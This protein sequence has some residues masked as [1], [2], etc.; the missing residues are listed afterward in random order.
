M[1]PRDMSEAEI[2]DAVVSKLP[3]EHRASAKAVA[4]SVP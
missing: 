4:R 2:I 3:A 1:H